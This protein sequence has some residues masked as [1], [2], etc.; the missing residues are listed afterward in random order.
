MT[1][2]ARSVNRTS[3]ILLVG[4]VMLGR[5]VDQ[6]FPEYH[7]DDSENQRHAQYFKKM[8]PK[9]DQLYREMNYTFPWGNTLPIFANATIRLINLETSATTHPAK[10]PDKA[11][12]YHMH[13]K[14]LEALKIARIE[15]ASLANN[16]ILD[17]CVPGLQETIKSLK[18][19]GIKFAGAGMNLDECM[20]PAVLEMTQ[21]TNLLVYSMADHFDFWAAGKDK[22]GIFFV[23]LSKNSSNSDQIVQ[24]ISSDVKKYK[25]NY[26][27]K[28][29]LPVVS[30]HMGSN[31]A[32]Q[33][34]AVEMQFCHDLIDKAGIDIIHGHSS[35]HVKGIEVYKGK[36]ILYGCGDF[37]D[38]YAVDR[39]YRNDLSFVYELIYN[40]DTKTFSHLELTPTQ[41]HLFQVNKATGDN[42]AW[43]ERTM[44]RLCQKLGTTVEK[45]GE[46]LRIPIK[47]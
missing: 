19:L 5:L 33:P 4:D 17:Y 30:I 14:N 31:Y 10:F 11:F 36:P 44:T 38:D 16:H 3:R 43:L 12:N 7:C 41:I 27:D 42:R 47:Q 8:Y 24:Y 34:T 35:H 39:E 37:E 13:P 1:S 29:W 45:D 22:P 9:V 21:D 23:D 20:R 18:E 40:H 2:S 15:Y 32:W 6:F 26:P 46:I 25:E 28:T